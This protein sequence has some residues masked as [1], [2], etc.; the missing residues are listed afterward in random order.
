M[1]KPKIS[2]LTWSYN[3]QNFLD[4][5]LKSWLDQDYPDYEIIAG[6]GPGI[7]VIED[8]RI[9]PIYTPELR[10]GMA[11][12]ALLKAA[13]GDVLM[14]TQS[15]MQV[16]SKTQLSRMFN[17]WRPGIMVTEK[18]IKDGRRDHGLFLQ[19]MMVEKKAILDIGG[20]CEEFDT[21]ETAAFEDSHIV[22]SLME[23]G[24]FY[25]HLE[26]PIDDTMYHLDHPK[27]DYNNDPVVKA[28]MNKGRDLYLS[29]HKY[30]VIV[31]YYKS[32]KIKAEYDKE[33][34]M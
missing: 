29:K 26:T 28:K 33:R 16:N 5:T 34:V 20:W 31:L 18:F 1:K 19:A 9:V 27:P 14:I 23:K 6:Y 10:M 13:T 15:D 32:L 7:E 21:G 22:A 12:N 8:P 2:I 24:L 25:R 30:H 4:I 17:L 11:Y 3:R